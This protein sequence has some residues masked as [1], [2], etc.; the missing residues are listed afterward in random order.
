MIPS[1]RILVIG[2][3]YSDFCIPAVDEA[4]KMGAS[5]PGARLIPMLA[6]PGGPITHPE[7][8]AALGA[9]L[10]ERSKDNLVRLLGVRA[11]ALGVSLPPITPSVRFG[12]PAESLLAE[13]KESHATHIFV[14]TRGRRGLEH[15]LLGSVAEEVTK[16]ASCSVLVAR[17][18]E[19]AA[20]SA[21]T[22]PPVT[23]PQRADEEEED[24]QELP[25]SVWDDAN[26]REEDEES[27]APPAQILSEPH[28]EGGRLVLHV[29]DVA[30]GQAFVAA[31]DNLETVRVEPLEGDWVPAPSSAARARAARAA[32]AEA[33]R[34]REI[35]E[36][37]SA[38]L[39]RNARQPE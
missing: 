19:G 37:L 32:V 10:V 16:S 24:T 4:L 17:A 12:R 27:A 25:R 39:E 28:I 3:D 21:M 35:F 13:A 23:E 30:S 38:E 8:A 20:V 31:F 6:L 9:E 15:F 18:P 33:K 14:G 7:S 34:T 36:Q 2:V 22:E 1:E 26:R 11:Q 29:L 5:A